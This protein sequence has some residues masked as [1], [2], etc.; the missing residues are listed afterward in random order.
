MKWTSLLEK[1]TER[2]YTV[3]PNNYGFKVHIIDSGL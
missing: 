1:A 3:L 2:I